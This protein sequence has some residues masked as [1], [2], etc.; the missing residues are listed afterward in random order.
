MKRE[1]EQKF[2]ERRPEWFRGR[3]ESLRTNLMAFGFDHDDGWFDLEWKLCEALEKVVPPKY[4]LMQ[5]KE[6]FGTLRWYDE[7][8][9]KE[10]DDLVEEAEKE[11]GKVCEVCGGLGYFCSS[12]YWVKTLCLE[13]L[14]KPEFK[15]VYKMYK[16][17]EK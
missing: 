2:F 17:K 15:G 8:N 16:E 4:K 14:E 9:T 5:I 6:K 11:S 7:G 3:N 10:G 1:L 12:G 13:C